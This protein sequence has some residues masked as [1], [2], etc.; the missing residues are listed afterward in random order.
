V[1]T[2]RGHTTDAV[3][4]MHY[5]AWLEAKGADYSEW[6][7]KMTNSYDPKKAGS[8]N[9]PPEFHDS[10][11]VAE[12]TTD[13]ILVCWARNSYTKQSCSGNFVKW[14]DPS[15]FFRQAMSRNT[16]SEA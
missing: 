10:T 2:S 13:W 6:F 11:W 15:A 12:R 1:E 16:N 7:P 8:W 4:D 14:P 9:I 3:P 5:R